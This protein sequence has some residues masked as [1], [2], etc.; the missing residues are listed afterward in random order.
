MVEGSDRVVPSKQMRLVS[1]HHLFI[2]FHQTFERRR[3][4]LPLT[5]PI[6]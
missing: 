6:F 5:L 2:M 3:R 1:P 4:S